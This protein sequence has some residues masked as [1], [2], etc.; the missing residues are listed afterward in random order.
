[1][2]EERTKK[3][4]S[5]QYQLQKGLKLFGKQ[6]HEAS[7]SELAQLHDRKCFQPLSV[8]TLTY[9]ERKKAQIAMMLLT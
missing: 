8:D 6:G 7:A 2:S 3:S 5:Q 1:M 9:G 4:F